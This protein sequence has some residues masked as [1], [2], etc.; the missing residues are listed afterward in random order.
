[1]ADQ[2]SLREKKLSSKKKK[3]RI[4]AA[5]STDIGLVIYWLKL[6]KAISKSG[7]TIKKENSYEV[8][9]TPMISKARL[10]NLVKDRFGVFADVL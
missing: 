8:S 2:F 6:N 10:R 9:V 7:V 5:Y 3:I 4:K 1:M